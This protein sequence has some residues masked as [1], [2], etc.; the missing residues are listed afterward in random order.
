MTYDQIL[1]VAGL[2]SFIIYGV[3]GVLMAAIGVVLAEPFKKRFKKVDRYLPVILVVSA[4]PI[5]TTYLMPK[6]DKMAFEAG[7]MKNI[8]EVPRQIDDITILQS[9]GVYDDAVN[10]NFQVTVDIEDKDAARA[11]ILEEWGSMAECKQLTSLP[12]KYA[13]KVIIRYETNLGEIIISLKPSDCR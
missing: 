3:I 4:M 1:W 11:V 10:Y 6:L 13:S 8:G 12:R 9:V 5:T 2:P 7:F